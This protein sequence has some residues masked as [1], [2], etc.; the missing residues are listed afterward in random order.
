MSME[1]KEKK[2]RKSPKRIVFN[3]CEADHEIIKHMAAAQR[4]TMSQWIINALDKAVRI[5]QGNI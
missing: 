3:I 5:Q 1:I 2:Q 4:M